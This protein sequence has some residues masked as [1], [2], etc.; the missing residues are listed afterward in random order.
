M[1][2]WRTRRNLSKS[3]IIHA[4]NYFLYH[5][6]FPLA[7]FRESNIWTN[8]YPI[9]WTNAFNAMQV[10]TE[11][12]HFYGNF[13]D[14]NRLSLVSTKTHTY[15]NKLAAFKKLFTVC[16]NLGLLAFFSILRFCWFWLLQIKELQNLQTMCHYTEYFQ[17]IPREFY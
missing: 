17:V 12:K 10:L 5:I 13:S 9:I 8:F 7:S 4:I 6:I 16:L 11:C 14:F 15:L 1:N 2:V 3:C